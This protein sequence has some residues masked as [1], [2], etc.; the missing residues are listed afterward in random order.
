M[1]FRRWWL[2]KQHSLVRWRKRG[3]IW[4]LAF[5]I[6]FALLYQT[7]W[8]VERNLKPTLIKIAEA[9]VKKATGAALREAIKEQGSLGNELD[10]LIRVEKDNE[11][12]IQF[13]QINQQLQAQIF[14]KMHR[15]M[16]REL[17]V[18]SDKPLKV[19]LGKVLQ[20]DLLAHYGPELPLEIWAKAAPRMSL[21]PRLQ[22]EGINTV[23]VTLILEVQT[24]VNV[25]IPFSTDAMKVRSEYS[26]V[27]AVVMGEVPRFY[28]YNDMGEIKRKESETQ[29][30][31]GQMP[32]LPPVHVDD[33]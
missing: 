9:E 26:L 32:I 11:G 31:S 27:Q 25:I 14:E 29:G 17:D 21:K 33:E 23:M 2:R 15:S 10:Q 12:R 18:L 8:L 20:S 13:I 1:R 4:F 24:E 6:F 22:A 28:Y 19:N 30:Q 5:A 3:G 16:V 7:L